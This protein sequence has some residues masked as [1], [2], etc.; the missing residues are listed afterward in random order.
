MNIQAVLFD[1]DGTLTKPDTIDFDGL[2]RAI[3]CPP[4]IMIL[5]YIASLPTETH[6][7]EAH[8]ILIEFKMDA[9]V[10]AQPAEDVEE[11]L[12]FLKKRNI[13]IGIVTRN[14]YESVERSLE[15]FVH[16]RAKDFNVIISEDTPVP[17]K[18]APDGILL[19]SK[20]LHVPTKH[21]L[22]VGDTWIDIVAG[23][24]ANTWTAL[25]APQPSPKCH[26]T[27]IVSSILELLSILQQHISMP[28]GKISN[29]LLNNLLKQLPINDSSL[30]VA[31][32]IGQDTAA[33]DISPYTVLT[34][35]SD[36]IT[37]ATDQISEYAVIINANDIAT[38][39][40]TPKWLSLTLLFPPQTTPFEVQATLTDISRICQKWGITICGGHTEITD[41]VTRLIISCTLLGIVESDKLIHKKNMRPGDFIYMTKEAGIEGTALIARERESLLQEKGLT[42]T[43][44]ALA[45]SYLSSISIL[46]EA[47]IAASIGVSGMHDITEGGIATALEEFSTAG[48][49]TFSIDMNQISISPVTQKICTLFRLSPLGLIGSGSLL[50][51]CPPTKAVLLEQKMK[52]AKISLYKIGIATKE[53]GKIEAHEGG[54]PIQWP[55]FEIDEIARFFSIY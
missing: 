4:D 36:P 48:N 46:P 41:S 32:G 31:P 22:M 51:S 55:Q 26:P 50:I 30:L 28:V 29:M 53:G 34:I 5:E 43:E 20:K 17:P 8:D 6:R 19:A 25:I 27:I 11:V 42:N 12:S 23:K 13:P 49:C 15:N 3:S 38:S 37:F 52:E 39:G 45:K 24:A 21:I 47:Q 54:S 1:F 2:R 16:F 9:A 18:P 35:K 10:R 7:K 14:I 44:I 40:A 33:I